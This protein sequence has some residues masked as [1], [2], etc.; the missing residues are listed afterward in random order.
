MTK[1]E[2]KVINVPL[3]D[4][5]QANAVLNQLGAEGWDAYEA[6]QNGQNLVTFLKRE[7]VGYQGPREKREEEKPEDNSKRGPGRPPKKISEEVAAAKVEATTT[8][9]GLSA[10]FPGDLK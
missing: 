8:I 6:V 4:T 7:L 1:L 5:R 3:G 10:Q 9:P 2:Y